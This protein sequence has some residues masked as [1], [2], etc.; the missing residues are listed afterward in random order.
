M[1]DAERK[2][3]RNQLFQAVMKI[4]GLT[5]QKAKKII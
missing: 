4:P 3:F 2:E 1:Q 5:K